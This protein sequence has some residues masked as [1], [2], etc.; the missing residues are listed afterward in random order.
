MVTEGFPEMV[1]AVIIAHSFIGKELIATAEYIVGKIES[2]TSVSIDYET[3]AFEARKA[4]SQAMKQVDQG[5]GI[6]LLTDLFGGSPCNIA[7]SFLNNEKVEVVTGVN[8]PMI[9]TFWSKRANTP[10][11]E[12]A[13]YVQLSGTRGIARARNLKE[14]T[15]AFGRRTRTNDKQLSQK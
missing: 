8:L 14:A 6:L 13:K 5:D 12:I 1:G 2:I 11:Q 9:L 4:I 10:L 3:N 7:F 15:G